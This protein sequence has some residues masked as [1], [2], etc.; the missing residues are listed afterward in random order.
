MMKR[1]KLAGVA[2]R[3]DRVGPAGRAASWSAAEDGTAIDTNWPALNSRRGGSRSANDELGDSV[4]D[5]LA[6]DQLGGDGGGHSGQDDTA[7]AAWLRRHVR[8]GACHGVPPSDRA[9]P[10]SCAVLAPS[11]ACQKQDEGSGKPAPVPPLDPAAA[12]AAPPPAPAAAPPPAAEP[13]AAA[14]APAAAAGRVDH[15]KDRAVRR[16]VAKTQA[17]RDAVPGC[18]RRISDNPTRARHADR[19]QEASRHVVPAAV[20]ADGRRHAVP[21]RPV[22]R[23]AHASPRASTRTAI[24]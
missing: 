16:P 24:R 12:P 18:A 17:A 9:R 13:A 5:R 8:V 20:L 19:R 2:L 15:R 14:P 7:R 22:R 1:S 11:L 10:R 6:R 23:R 3:G 4:R 21:E